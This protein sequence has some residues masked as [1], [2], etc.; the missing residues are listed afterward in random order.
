MTLRTV[1]V[2]LARPLSYSVDPNATFE[3]G[4]V[5]QLRIIGNDIVMGV[6]DGTAP[7]GLI[8][9]NKTIAFSKSVIDEIT[10]TVSL[11]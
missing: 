7:F 9:D 6:S 11:S 4:M 2:G 1:Q 8:D 10:S 5:A 3:A